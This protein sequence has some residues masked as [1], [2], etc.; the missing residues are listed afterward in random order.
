MS[1]CTR[2]REVKI[3]TKAEDEGLLKMIEAIEV[4]KKKESHPDCMLILF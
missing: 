2:E 1:S 3:A 4:R